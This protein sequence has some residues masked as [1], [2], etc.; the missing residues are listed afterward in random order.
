MIH[1]IATIASHTFKESVREKTLYNLIAFAL[2]LIVASFL[3]G[4]IS[5]GIQRIMLVNLGLTAIAV[6]GLLISI[7]I[8]ISLV[9]REIDRRTLFNVLSKP[10]TR[11]EFIVGKYLGLLLTLMVN[12]GMM[13]AGFYA[14]LFLMD[15]RV[16]MADLGTLEA[17]YFIVLELA[18]VV[19]V[20]LLFSCIST[21]A[22][23]AV[24][25]FCV[26]V[27]GNFAADIR[28]FGQESGSWAVTKLTTVLYYL[29]PNFSGFNVISLA[30][31]GHAVPGYLLLSNSLYALLYAAILISASVLIFEERELT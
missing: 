31:H 12:T 23:S 22:L 5:I 10:V 2:L 21:P 15:R 19:G 17:V 25:T 13:A 18:L 24:F 4:K 29:L 9:W 11:W 27:I 26:F 7:F 16:Q 6:F 1:R 30:A 14:A 3:F 8:G 28:W 20:A